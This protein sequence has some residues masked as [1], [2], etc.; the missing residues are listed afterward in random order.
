MKTQQG[1]PIVN[2]DIPVRIG[3]KGTGAHLE[4]PLVTFSE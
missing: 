4:N 2:W 3:N 1:T